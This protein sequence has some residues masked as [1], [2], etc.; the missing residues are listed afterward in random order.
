[1]LAQNPPA[2]QVKAKLPTDIK[3]LYNLFPHYLTS[4]PTPPDNAH[5]QACSGLKAF[6]TA[7]TSTLQNH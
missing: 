1:M 4:S 2:D 5:C 6:V 3:A 7:V